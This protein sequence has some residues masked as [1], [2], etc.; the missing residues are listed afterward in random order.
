MFDRG[1]ETIVGAT[2]T[3]PDIGELLHSA[4]IAIAGR[5]PFDRLRHAVPCFPALS[6]VWLMLMEGFE[7]ERA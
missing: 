5:V 7:R 1:S 3:G 6:E 2:F 4:T